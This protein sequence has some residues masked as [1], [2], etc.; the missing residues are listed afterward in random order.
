[1]TRIAALGGAYSNPD[2]LRAALSDARRRGCERIVFLGDLGGFGADPEGIAPLVQADDVE[3]IAGNYDLA[4]AS[5]ADDCGCGYS[6][7]RDNA[8]A[9]L[10]YDYTRA[11]T[12]GDFARWMGGLPREWRARLDGVE[13]H[14]VHGSPLAVNDFFWESLS[15]A[16][17]GERVAASG[18]DVLL[19]THTGIPWQRMIAGTLVVNV[20]TVGRNAN[21][22]RRCGWY[23]VIET[24][25]GSARAELVPVAFDWRAQATAMREAGLPEAF[26]ASVETGWWTSCLEIVPPPERARG[27]FQLYAEDLARLAG[28][29]SEPGE[30]GLPVRPLFGSDLFPARLWLYSNF[31]CNLACDYCAVSSSPTARRR[32]LGVDRARELIDDGIAHGVEE[33]YFTGGEPLLEPDIARMVAHAADRGPTVLLTNAMLLNGRRLDAFAPLAG[34]PQLTIQ[35]SL[36]GATPA[37]NDAM[38]GRNAFEATVAGIAAARDL[39]L[40]VAVSTTETA[41]NRD[42]IPALRALVA[43]LGVAAEDHAVRPLVARGESTEGI[44]VTD[45]GLVPELTVSADGWHWHPVGA[46]ADSSPDLLVAPSETSLGRA[47]DLITER[48][49]ARRLEQGVLP[50]PYAC[51]VA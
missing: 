12:S 47:V 37:S 28:G 15:E 13:V 43:E 27:R 26:A 35:T 46:D 7:P 36:D 2:A 24:E 4:I 45:S 31:H 25:A 17:A 44:E 34:H 21:D 22:G 14:G 30:N 5:G 10:M 1:M 40:R 3:C 38:R 18:A 16:E 49:L 29:V 50:A 32:S 42:E 9:Q 6:N 33:I 41:A 39:G 11:H 51:A 48:F 19:C 23:A 20:G 8:W